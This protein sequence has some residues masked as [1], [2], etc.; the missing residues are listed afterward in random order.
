MF[1]ELAFVVCLA[2]DPGDCREERH[3]LVEPT[4]VM[5]CLMGAQPFLA[6]WAERNPGWA[7]SRWRC[8][9]IDPRS[10]EI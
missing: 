4:T 1:I 9:A 2:A 5:G 6:A 3:L 8:G 10:A 7:V